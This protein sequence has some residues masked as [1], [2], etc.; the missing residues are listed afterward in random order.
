MDFWTVERKELEGDLRF[1][2]TA[3]G[4]LERQYDWVVSDHDVWYGEGCPADVREQWQWTGLLLTGEEL[5]KHLEYVHFVSSGVLSAVPKGTRREAVKP[6]IPYWEAV[7]DFSPDYRFQT[8]L[9]QLE[10]I[11]YDGYAWLI[12]CREE[13]SSRVRQALPRARPAKKF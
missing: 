8:P 9:T 13:F 10:I 4:D 5:V 11:C 7:G 6:Y 12:V 2:L 1:L 3:L